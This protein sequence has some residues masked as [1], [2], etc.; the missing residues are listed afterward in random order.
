M[1]SRR[2]YVN[3][4]LFRGSF[5]GEMLF[6]ILTIDQGEYVGVAPRRDTLTREN[7]TIRE[8]STIPENGIAGKLAARLI[9]NGGDIARVALPD[10]EA[11]NVSVNEIS[12]RE[13]DLAHVSV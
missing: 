4:T 5:S 2:I 13:P 3:C 1:N 8:N 10:G 7:E 9:G 6:S 11:I 12:E